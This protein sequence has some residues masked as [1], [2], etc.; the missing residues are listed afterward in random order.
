MTNLSKPLR[1]WLAE[2]FDLMPAV[3]VLN[4]QSEDVT[5][6]LLLELRDRSLIET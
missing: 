2:T 4:K 6:K 1:A 5:D 3:L